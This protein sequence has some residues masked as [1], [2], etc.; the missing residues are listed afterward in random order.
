MAKVIVEN[1][2]NDITLEEVK[3]HI[4]ETLRNSD[5]VDYVFEETIK[6]LESDYNI[7]LESPNQNKEFNN[8]Y[9]KVSI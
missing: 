1:Y 7:S 3:E 5:F 9:N 6:K 2:G 4:S 8:I